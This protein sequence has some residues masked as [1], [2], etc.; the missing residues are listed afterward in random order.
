MFWQL[1]FI[2]LPEEVLEKLNRGDRLSEAEAAMAAR[3]PAL[4]ESLLAQ[5]P[6]LDGVREILAAC[7]KPPTRPH[8]LAAPLDESARCRAMAA[9]ILRLAIDLDA[10][11]VQGV[12]RDLVLNTLSGRAERYDPDVLASLLAKRGAGEPNKQ[13]Q[14]LPDSALRVGMILFEDLQMVSGAL[15]AARGFEINESFVERARNFRTGTL[16]EPIKVIVGAGALGPRS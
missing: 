7:G 1:G 3:A 9:Q 10:L 8:P 16:R 6:R 11:E 13:I 14:E 12:E 15:M 5:I 2:S 4:S